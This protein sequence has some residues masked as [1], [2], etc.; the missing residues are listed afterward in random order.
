LNIVK[1]ENGG[2]KNL[3][4]HNERV[5][6]LEELLEKYENIKDMRDKYNV[7]DMG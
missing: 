3:G 6:R 7:E 5:V 1:C 2:F 4:G